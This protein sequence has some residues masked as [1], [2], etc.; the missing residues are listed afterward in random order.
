M[1][2]KEIYVFFVDSYNNNVLEKKVAKNIQNMSELNRPER[3]CSCH[4]SLPRILCETV[5]DFVA[6]VGK[7]YEKT[8]DNTDECDSMSLKVSQHLNMTCRSVIHLHS[9]ETHIQNMFGIFHIGS[10]I[11]LSLFWFPKNVV[12]S[13]III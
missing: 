1:C 10:D 13:C 6:K 11:Y 9:L 2:G 8:V 5:K 12:F 3:Y 4:S 7:A